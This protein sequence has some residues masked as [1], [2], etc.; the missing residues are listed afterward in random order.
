MG[1]VFDA[2]CYFGNVY[3]VLTWCCRLTEEFGNEHNRFGK[4]TS[5]EFVHMAGI[6]IMVG[7]QIA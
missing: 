7:H 4:L 2:P 1:L 6:G 3:R 5:F